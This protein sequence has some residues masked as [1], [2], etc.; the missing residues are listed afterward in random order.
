MPASSAAHFLLRQYHRCTEMFAAINSI[1]I[2][3][4]DI[5]LVC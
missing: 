2:S 3:H 1:E 5:I 4:I